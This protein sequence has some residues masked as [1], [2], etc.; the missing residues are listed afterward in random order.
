MIFF[1]TNF[2]HNKL[3]FVA[4][5]MI[6]VASPANDSFMC[7]AQVNPKSFVRTDFFPSL[8]KK[9]L[10]LRADATGDCTGMHR[11]Y[12][13]SIDLL[14]TANSLADFTK[15]ADSV[16]LTGSRRS[17]GRRQMRGDKT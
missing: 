2:C 6:Q 12:V 13:A 5:K 11:C 7:S 3:T 4:T 16:R 15:G 14:R 10:L 1:A 17:L 8:K 9:K